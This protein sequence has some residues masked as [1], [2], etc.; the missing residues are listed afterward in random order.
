MRM[1]SEE[2]KKKDQ[3]D[4]HGK[5]KK[6]TE[7]RPVTGIL[8]FSLM[9]TKRKEKGEKRKKSGEKRVGRPLMLLPSDAR[10]KKERCEEK[11]GRKEIRQRIKSPL[12]IRDHL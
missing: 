11:K 4:R 7:S 8:D 9:L 12:L 6:E 1:R 2:K 3:L 5:E 10:K